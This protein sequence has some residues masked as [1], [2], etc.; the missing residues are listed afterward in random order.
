MTHD[1]R[2]REVIAAELKACFPHEASG[3]DDEASAILTALTAAGLRVV[4]AEQSDEDVERVA[5]GLC[6]GMFDPDERDD[7]GVI[8][9]TR[10]ADSARAAIRAF[11]NGAP[12][13]PP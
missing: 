6:L 1:P 13:A 7:L 4:P 11:L 3:F 5:R 8:R 2:A 9:W 10:Y 12:D